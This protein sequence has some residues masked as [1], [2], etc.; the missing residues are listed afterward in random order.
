[1]SKKLSKLCA[2]HQT[3]FAHSPNAISDVEQI[4]FEIGL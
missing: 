3:K 2:D 4:P 1:L